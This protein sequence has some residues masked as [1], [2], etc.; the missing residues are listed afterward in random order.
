MILK[1]I[2][3]K[4]SSIFDNFFSI[5]RDYFT[6]GGI[7]KDWNFF[8][9]KSNIF[10]HLIDRIKFQ[11]YPKLLISASFPTHLEVEVQASVR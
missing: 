11:Y 3:K 4:I 9:K 8:V 5:E 1:N 7:K 2:A 10:S 6:I